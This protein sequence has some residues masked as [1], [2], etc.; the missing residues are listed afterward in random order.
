MR[1]GIS[2]QLL[3]VLVMITELERL[4]T[5]DGYRQYFMDVNI[6]RPHIQAVCR[7]HHLI[8]C[9]SI[10]AGLAGSFPTFIVENH[11][12]VKFFGRFYGGEKA[13]ETE[14]QVNRLLQ[15]KLVIPLPALLNCGKL[16]D[17]D[18]TLVWHYLIFEYIPGNSIGEIYE[19]V[20]FDDKIALARNL[21]EATRQMIRLPLDHAPIFRSGLE[22]FTFFLHTQRDRCL[23]NHLQWHSLPSH[24]I[25]QIEDYLLPVETLVE[26]RFPHG[27]IHADITRDHILG[28]IEADRWVTLGLIDFGD[29]RVGNV[30]YDLP[31]L[32]IDL[33]QCDKRL[34]RAYLEAYGFWEREEFVHQAMSVALLHEFNI[35]AG[36]SENLP[37]AD[38]AATLS[39]LAMWIWDIGS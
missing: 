14:L 26:S 6:W 13:Y 19:Q 2:V 4:E 1:T 12:V 7:R 11:W 33:F 28:H 24:L 20:C 27:L 22:D 30:Y 8:P 39:E 15:T 32:H 16:S 31:A 21:G 38:Q 18:P 29:A 35:F 3:D 36:L 25:E 9:Q 5:V 10:R 37:Q 23:T 34:L 17:D